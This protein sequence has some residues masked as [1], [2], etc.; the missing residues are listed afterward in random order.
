MSDI[1]LKSKFQIDEPYK[2]KSKSKFWHDLQVGDIVEITHSLSRQ[3]S[4]SRGYRAIGFGLKNTRTG[5]TE[6]AT[7]NSLL[8]YMWQLKV[9]AINN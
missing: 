5:Q 9:T 6:Y 2:G 4:N 1:I 7:N 8:Q 3:G